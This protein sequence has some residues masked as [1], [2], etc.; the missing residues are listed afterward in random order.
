MCVLNAKLPFIGTKQQE[1]VRAVQ[2][3]TT[4]ILR[5]RS[6]NVV[7]WVL[8]LTTSSN[9]ANAILKHQI[10]I[11]RQDSAWHVQNL[12]FGTMIHTNANVQ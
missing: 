4:T 12:I 3:T 5:Q 9:V 2:W 8:N 11:L 6:V 10:L 7:L 1:Y